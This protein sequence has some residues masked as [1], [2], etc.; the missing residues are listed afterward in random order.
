MQAPRVMSTALQTPRPSKILAKVLAPTTTCCLRTASGKHV[1]HV[2][3]CFERVE[4]FTFGG[5]RLHIPELEAGEAPVGRRQLQT[6]LAQHLGVPYTALFFDWRRGAEAGDQL[7]VDVV[8]VLPWLGD[9]TLCVGCGEY[10]PEFERVCAL[11]AHS[12]VCRRCT[13]ECTELPFAEEGDRDQVTNLP[14][15]LP[16]LVCV[17]CLATNKHA[18]GATTSTGGFHASLL[19]AEFI[20][21]DGCRLVEFL[22]RA[23]TPLE[24]TASLPGGATGSACRSVRPLSGQRPH[25]I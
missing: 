15:Q 2:G 6:L 14:L 11:C 22:E 16:C 18:A 17:Q 4:I 20:Y 19:R 23:S 25:T 9:D 8:F 3:P 5:D 13:Y 21:M 24:T 7:A 10:G 12:G 1:A